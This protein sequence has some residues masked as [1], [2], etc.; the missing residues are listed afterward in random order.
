MENI[1]LVEPSFL[2]EDIQVRLPYSTGLIWSHCKTNK[3]IEKNYKLSD[4]LFVRDEIDKF[5]DNIH[6]PS[7]IG[8]SCFVWNWAF[9]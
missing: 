5:V 7:V 1:Y 4:I 2:Y 6:N 9:N 8:F 3:I